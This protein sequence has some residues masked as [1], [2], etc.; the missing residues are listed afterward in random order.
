M[1]ED[2]GVVEA[3]HLHAGARAY[4]DVATAQT[5]HGGGSGGDFGRRG[6]VDVD[7]VLDAGA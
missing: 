1:D 5:G 7:R 4:P 3:V 6:G 2:G